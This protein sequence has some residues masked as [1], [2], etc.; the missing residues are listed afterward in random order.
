MERAAEDM[1]AL[2]WQCHSYLCPLQVQ[3]IV[4]YIYDSLQGIQKIAIWHCFDSLL[5]KMAD[6]CPEEVV[7]TLLNIAPQGDRYWP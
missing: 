5:L 3:K 6:K 2:Q 4:S 1:A 7:T